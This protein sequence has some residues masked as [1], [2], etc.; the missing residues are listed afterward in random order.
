[1]IKVVELNHTYQEWARSLLVRRWHSI[2]IVSKG[3]KHDASNLPGLVALIDGEPMGLL[4]Y[5]VERKSCELITIDSLIDGLGIGWTLVTHLRQ[6]LLETGCKRLWLITTNDNTEALRFYQ[7]RGFVLVAL[8][9]EALEKSRRL[10]PEIPLVGKHGIRLR[11]E[12][13]LEMVLTGNCN[14]NDQ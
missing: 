7:K 8:H 10:K 9:C 14:E 5:R 11:D 1:M 6:L 4:T 12:L 13:E 2:Y 3:R